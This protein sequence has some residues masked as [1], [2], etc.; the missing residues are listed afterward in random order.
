MEAASLAACQTAEAGG[1][2]APV[3]Q[4]SFPFPRVF[5]QA[6]QTAFKFLEECANK[7]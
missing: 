4:V 2:K 3:V 1:K 6:R 5:S 7:I